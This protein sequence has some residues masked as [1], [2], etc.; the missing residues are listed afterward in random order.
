MIRRTL[1]AT[2]L[3][4]FGLAASPVHATP[5][6]GFYVFGDSLSDVGNGA[7]WGS[8]VSGTPRSQTAQILNP[9]FVPPGDAPYAIADGRL[10]RFSNGAMWTERFAAAIGAP[11]VPSFLGGNIFAAGGA[12][13]TDSNLAAAYAP[14]LAQQLQLY[15]Q[16]NGP[17][18]DPNALYVVA[19]GGNDARTI[20]SGAAAILGDGDP[21]NDATLPGFIQAGALQYA[22]SVTAAVLALQA[23]GA[24]HLIVWNVPDLGLT[25]LAQAVSFVSPGF[26]ILATSVAAA[27]NQA[28]GGFLGASGALADGAQVF[29]V[30]GQVQAIVADPAQ[31]GLTNAT[32]PCG[33]V[34]VAN[35]A[36]TCAGYL[37]WDSIHPAAGGQRVIAEQMLAAAGVPLPG[38]LLLIGIG[39]AGLGLGARAARGRSH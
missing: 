23:M 11:A 17:M 19:I 6:S 9:V 34:V 30:F 5:Y 16:F 33:A 2:A 26:D 35:P 18:A 32:V 20:V 28:L 31:F 12:E 14:S 27:M 25:P 8:A 7:L 21:T 36:E 15:T 4:L 38:T 22:A 29:D 3:A 13:A 39:L 10:D 1:A 24:D 37:F